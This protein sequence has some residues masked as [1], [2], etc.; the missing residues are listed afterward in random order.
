ML[1][2]LLRVHRWTC[3]AHDLLGLR[4]RTSKLGHHPRL[5]MEGPLGRPGMGR[6]V[7]EDTL[8]PCPCRLGLR[9]I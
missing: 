6:Q 2:N 4:L 7:D 5:P 1:R 9:R 3:L 8:G